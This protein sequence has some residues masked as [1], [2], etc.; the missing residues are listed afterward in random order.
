MKRSLL[1]LYAAL[2]LLL[3][4]CASPSY[5]TLSEAEEKGA[6]LGEH[7]SIDGVDVSGLSPGEAVTQVEQ[8][9]KAALAGQSYRI[10]ADGQAL[11]LPA[12]S[13]PISF[14]TQEV[15]LAALSL[16]RH[17]VKRNARTLSCAPA[18][19]LEA[20]RAALSA[21]TAS[22]NLEPTDCTVAY[23]P[24]AEGRFT[25]TEAQ[26]GRRADVHALAQTLQ[27]RILAGDAAPVE[28]SF[29]ELAP[30]YTLEQA[31]ADRTLIA[32]FS[33]SFAKS[34]YG[35]KNRVFNIQKAAKRIDGA[36][37]AP[38]QEF[39][40]NALLGPRNEKT[41]WRIATGILNGTYVQEYG[42]GVCQ[43]SS[44][45]YNAVLMADLTVTERHHHSWPLGYIDAGRDATIS[46]GGPNLRFLNSSDAPIVISADVDAKEK[47]VTVRIYGRPL[48]EGV[49][50][51]LHSKKTATLQ[52]L[53]TEYVVDAS[54][55]PGQ[56]EEVRK[57]RR[58]CIAVAWKEYHDAEG[59]LLRTEQVTE[60][61]YR[62]IRG[63]IKVS[64]QQNINA[65]Q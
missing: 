45:L 48:P 17:V 60:D 49:S 3:C 37:L 65:A 22:L 63:L 10:L 47:T 21:H 23:D 14:N 5:S 54:L 55:P 52:D 29:A 42:G 57:S 13:L 58:G 9:Q 27:N 24:K 28:V 39:D 20:L 53:G 44:T 19:E 15:V 40:M 64:I 43:V 8:A 16:P 11:D 18:V 12:D 51:T 1:C 26:A 61:K 31:R 41:G 6:R 25:F 7:I 46:T 30:A 35:A 59:N 56:I 38:G 32:E 62:S 4:A 34:P 2:M 36:L 50:I 33:T